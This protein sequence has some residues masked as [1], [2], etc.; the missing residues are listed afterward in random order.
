M[1]RG[2]PWLPGGRWLDTR[3][4]PLLAA[5]RS[6]RRGARERIAGQS[7]MC[8]AW[9][10]RAQGPAP[11]AECTGMEGRAFCGRGLQSCPRPTTQ[12]PHVC[13]VLASPSAMLVPFS[14]D[15]PTHLDHCG[16]SCCARHSRTA[17][18]EL[19]SAAAQAIGL[20][21]TP[22]A[23]DRS[24]CRQGHARVCAHTVARAARLAS[25]LRSIC[26]RRPPPQSRAAAGAEDRTREPVQ[27]ITLL[28]GRGSS[29]P[30]SR[31]RR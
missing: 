8:I 16:G 22:A 4:R 1:G 27:R 28:R 6:G 18:P 19:D 7:A 29:T 2:G 12:S 10:Q 20:F 31:G 3:W 21:E 30:T 14:T 23:Q 5:T 24:P 17:S 26:R 11:Q 9:P 13:F 15:F 25:A